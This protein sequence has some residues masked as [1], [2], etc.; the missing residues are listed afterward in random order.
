MQFKPLMQEKTGRFFVV[1]SNIT[2][3]SSKMDGSGGVGP[4]NYMSRYARAI[5]F[6]VEFIFKRSLPGA[7]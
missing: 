7:V 4:A 6:Q 5:P 3:P 1:S 2:P